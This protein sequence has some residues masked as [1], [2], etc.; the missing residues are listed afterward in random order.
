VGNATLKLDLAAP[1]RLEG[2]FDYGYGGGNRSSNPT[3][4]AAVEIQ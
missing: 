2:T 4:R 3:L 1:G